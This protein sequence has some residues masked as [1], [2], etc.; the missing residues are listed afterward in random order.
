M[1]FYTGENIDLI[2][3]MHC[4][5]LRTVWVVWVLS[6]VTEQLWS[7]QQQNSQLF[8]SYTFIC[9]IKKTL[10]PLQG[11]GKNCALGRQKGVLTRVGFPCSDFGCHKQTNPQMALCVLQGM[12]WWGAVGEISSPFVWCV[13]SLCSHFLCCCLSQLG[14]D[15]LSW[16]YE[17]FS[18]MTAWT[19]RSLMSRD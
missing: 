17:V 19:V 16:R 13:W 2:K 1:C 15:F 6:N 14:L 5:I 11:E 8:K 10:W 3:S 4:T 7:W 18:I 12:R 9:K